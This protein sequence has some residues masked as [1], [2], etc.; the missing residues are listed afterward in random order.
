MKQNV[1]KA[2]QI[3]V[4][5]LAGIFLFYLVYKKQNWQETFQA[6]SESKYQWLLLSVFLGL[7]SHLS[8][9]VR[10]RLLLEP[11]G[12]KPRVNVLFYSVMVMYLSN[13]A[14]PRSGEV[15][16]C[17][18]T[19]KY[20]KIPF[21]TL[22]GT[23]VTERIID[24][25]ILFLLI[26]IAFISQI[27]VFIDF[28]NNNQEVKQKLLN[29]L[30]SSVFILGTVVFIMA[31]LIGAYIFRDK[32]KQTKIYKKFQDIIRNFMSGIKSIMHLEKKWQ[33]LA[34]SLF[35]WT[36]YFVMIYVCFMA[37]DFTSH[38]GIMTGL[39][40][41]V[42]ASL[43][44]VA[45]SPG[46]MGTWHFMAIETLYIYGIDK[47]QGKIFAFAAHESQMLMLI[48]IGLISYA[49]LFF[50]KEKNSKNVKNL[51]VEK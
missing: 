9:A 13:L 26:L 47:T 4:F 37:F 46:G 6:I 3:A 27:G 34:H 14:I 2:L 16:R 21:S 30:N 1:K 10:W 25:I 17:S 11:L 50:V 51:S 40:V 19:A 18:V 20:E 12:Y 45:P 22:L 23:V 33:F 38:L 5:I 7:L 43:G 24:V 49:A 8:R 29:L 15:V 28:L 48:V 32:I 42:M 41:F 31:V 39:M 36:M 35:I 44:M